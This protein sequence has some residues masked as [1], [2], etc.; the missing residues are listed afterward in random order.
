MNES[1][2]GNNFPSFTYFEGTNDMDLDFNMLS[3]Y[4]L[5]DEDPSKL[6]ILPNNKTITSQD[7]KASAVV[8]QGN[9]CK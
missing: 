1:S 5:V 3:E 8:G 6:E 2:I 4:L 9:I 7:L